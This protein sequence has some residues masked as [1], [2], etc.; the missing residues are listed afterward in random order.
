M[1]EREERKGGQERRKARAISSQ[2]KLQEN[3]VCQSEDC[4]ASLFSC[5]TTKR[6]SNEN[7]QEVKCSHKQLTVQPLLINIIQHCI[8]CVTKQ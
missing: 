3:V 8:T 6:L 2:T 4:H 7:S 1:N 5:K